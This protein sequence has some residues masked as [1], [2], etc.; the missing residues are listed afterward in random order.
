[1]RRRPFSGPG[2]DRREGL[3][4]NGKPYES[5]WDFPRP[6]QIEQVDWRI[7]VVHAGATVVVVASYALHVAKGSFVIP[8]CP[9]V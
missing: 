4:P 9:V 5:V 3:A 6:P 2:P 8:P 1:M 7:R